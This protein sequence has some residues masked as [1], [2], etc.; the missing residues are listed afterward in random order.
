MVDGDGGIVTF[1]AIATRVPSDG[2]LT[3]AYFLT[4]N[5]CLGEIVCD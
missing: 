5:I 4:S 2:I 3:P 1:D